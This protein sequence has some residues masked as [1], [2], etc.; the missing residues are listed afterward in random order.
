ME[1]RHV[2]VFLALAEEL[3]FGRTAARLRVAQSAVSETI[4]AL[5]EEIGAQLFERTKRNVALSA[6]GH[7]FRAHAEHSVR[8]LE[9]GAAAAR[10]AGDGLTGSLALRFTTMTALTVVPRAIAC[11]RELYPAVEIRIEAAGGTAQLEAIAR[12]A[13]DV[14]FVALRTDAPGLTLE[15]IERTHVVVLAG[16]SHALA[17][18]R[19]AS[20]SNFE[21]QRCV[22]MS[23]RN[24]P[25]VRA[26][27]R[28]R[29]A[30]AGVAPE[31]VLEVDQLETILAFVASGLGISV[32][33]AFVARLGFPGVACVPLRPAVPAG[34][35]AV[36]DPR[37][38]SAVG[39]RFLDVVRENVAAQRAER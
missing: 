13:C 16:T 23:T 19:S 37:T 28:R 29:F 17:R 30:E 4:R 12:G 9:S 32:A 25:G 2:R 31:T 38:L 3:H 5:E 1:M 21:G 35:S 8:E 11:F 6:A 10:R 36:W 27:L 18:K 20:W 14:G 7:A 33:P 39:R 24:E 34:I 15:V 22:L 26:V